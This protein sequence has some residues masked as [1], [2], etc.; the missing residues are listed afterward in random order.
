MNAEPAITDLAFGCT[1][2]SWSGALFWDGNAHCAFEVLCGE[3][4]FAL[5]DVV[6]GALSDELTAARACSGT[7]VEDMV[8]RA[9]RVFV[10]FHYD[11]GIPE[12][13]EVAE[14]L[15]EAVVVALVESDAWLVENIED[16]RK[17]RADLCGE[18]YALSLAAGKRSALAVELE[19]VETHF[20]EKMQP[21][22]DFAQDILYDGGVTLGELQVRHDIRRL[23]DC[24]AANNLNAKLHAGLCSERDGKNLGAQAGTLADAAHPL[25]LKKPEALAGKLAFGGFVEV[26][27]LC[28]NALKGLGRSAVCADSDRDVSF[29]RAVEDKIAEIFR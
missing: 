8:G 22:P 14:G 23:A 10:M 6:E 17:S 1:R 3:G 21:L 26:N 29:C 2:L 11:D 12:V 7:N 9:N 27:E 18:P 25:A 20:V 16:A 15:D 28:E 13:A 24:E 19:V 5:E 4:L